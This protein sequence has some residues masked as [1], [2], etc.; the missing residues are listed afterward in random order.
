M[1]LLSRG[2]EFSAPA[3]GLQGQGQGEI[4]LLCLGDASSIKNSQ[5][6]SWEGS[7]VGQH[8]WVLG[9]Q[10]GPGALEPIP[11]AAP[12][13]ALGV[14]PS[15]VYPEPFLMNFSMCMDSFIVLRVLPVRQPAQSGILGAWLSSCPD[16]TAG[17]TSP[18]RLA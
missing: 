9:S 8:L 6:Q 1:A 14:S 10:R 16:R 7:G 13:L 4:S 12:H 3:L 2:L 11:S 5:R 15:A 18:S 17:V